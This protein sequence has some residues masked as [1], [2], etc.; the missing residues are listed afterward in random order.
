VR[1]S[2]APAIRHVES[3]T[4]KTGLQGLAGNK[5]GVGIR[6]SLYDSTMCLMTCHL[7]AG[8]SNVAERNAD[9]KTVN[10]GL[11]FLRGK[12]IDDHE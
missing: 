6:F 1:S 11:R 8:H 3:A 10:E 2:L 4:K 9:Y 7:A 12:V 5:G